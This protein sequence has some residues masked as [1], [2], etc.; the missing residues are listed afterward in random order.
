MWLDRL[1][2][3]SS[4]PA[5][6]QPPSRGYSPAPRRAASGQGP[7]VTSQQ[8]PTISQRNSSLSIASADSSTSSLLASS[9]RATGSTL[10]QTTTAYTGPDPVEVLGSLLGNK[11]VQNFTSTITSAD[12]KVGFDFGGLSLRALALSEEPLSTVSDGR[13]HQSTDECGCS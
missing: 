4:S 1:A 11:P 6:S 9:R 10:K 2:G 13:K 5:S 8:R 3:Q 12:L 7:Y